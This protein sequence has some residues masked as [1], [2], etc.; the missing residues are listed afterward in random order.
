MC[1][2]GTGGLETRRQQDSIMSPS[3]INNVHII[4]SL[5][6]HFDVHQERSLT[7][8][9]ILN[10]CPTDDVSTCKTKLVNNCLL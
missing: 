8:V 1:E 4:I 10:S 2:Q 9:H 6:V 7:T 5:C 3:V